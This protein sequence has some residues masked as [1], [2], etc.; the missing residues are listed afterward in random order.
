MY[1][2]YS[3][4]LEILRDYLV[5]FA[6]AESQLNEHR[7]LIKAYSAFSFYKLIAPKSQ[8]A[9]DSSPITTFIKSFT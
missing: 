3:M 6:K 9:L 5:S 8:P 2:F 1:N 4:D 7:N